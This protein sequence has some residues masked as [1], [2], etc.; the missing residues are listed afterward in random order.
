MIFVALDLET[1]G[2]SPETDTIIEI[3]AIRFE[4]ERDGDVFTMS[5][6]E[7]HS[8]LIHPGR[9][10]TQEVTMIT[11]ITPAMLDGKPSWDSVR[12]KVREFIGD[13][14]IVGHNVLF[15]I[16]MFASHGIELSSNRVID[17]FELSEIFSRDIESLNLG[18]LANR[19]GLIEASED[20]HRALTDTKVS[21]RL[22][23]RYLGEV[24]RVSGVKKQIWNT[25]SSRDESHT[26]ATL[27]HIC[28]G[29][30]DANIDMSELFVNLLWSQGIPPQSNTPLSHYDTAGHPPTS[31]EIPKPPKPDAL[32]SS[33]PTCGEGDHDSGGGVFSDI[34]NQKTILIE[35]HGDPSEEIQII[36]DAFR[37]HSHIALVT[38][39]YKVASW[40][41]GL[42]N[43][44]N[45]ENIIAITPDKWCSVEYMRELITSDRILSRKELILT[46]KIAYWL[47]ETITWLLDEMKYYGD[48]RNMLDIYRCRSDESHLWR[49]QYEAKIQTIPVLIIDAYH[50]AIEI[51]GRHT[52]IKD[53]PLLEDIMRRYSS[54]EVSFDKLS[55]AISSLPGSEPLVHLWDM[56]S[57]IR[58]IYETIPD[59]PTGPLISPPGSHG[60]TYFV[61][62]AMLWHRGYKWLVHASRTLENSW[63]TYKSEHQNHHPRE[64]QLNIEYIDR[65]IARLSSYHNIWDTNTNI[66]LSIHEER[67]RLTFI[68]R[69]VSE[70]MQPLLDGSTSYGINIYRPMTHDF[71]SR[72]Y[73]LDSQTIKPSNHQTPDPYR[74]S[75]WNC[76][77]RNRDT[78]DESTARPRPRIRTEKNPRK[79]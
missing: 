52:I 35:T 13:A 61:T 36:H 47:T 64:V 44:N 26:L 50:F 22:F 12:D 54:V 3:A 10:L 1:T 16:A 37:T 29:E 68:P 28:H 17:T 67:T 75:C 71:L 74:V 66:I 69:R 70:M 65:S 46:L 76:S 31:G 73:G 38:P 48:E 56:I 77:K 8:Q 55:D 49:E 19:Y 24:S 63:K 5:R 41:S 6:S 60:E 4:I 32:C 21:I 79:K 42:L 45:I 23:L 62:Q 51:P 20:E 30:R 14:V 53:I 58:D 27:S 40:M 9:V 59:R 78:H 2:L 7:E 25:L 18:F 43:K 15:D 33:L 72:E 34:V 11:G 39:G 57:I